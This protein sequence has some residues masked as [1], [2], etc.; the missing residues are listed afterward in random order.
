[1]K[2]ICILLALVLALACV[3]AF[4]AEGDALLGISNENTLNFSYC[5]SQ[6]GTLYLVSYGVLYTYHVG[7]SDLKEYSI[8]RAGGPERRHAAA[9]S[10]PRCP[11]PRT[12]S[13]IPSIWSRNTAR[14]P[15]SRAPL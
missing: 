8:E 10:S 14:T 13:S 6:D 1:M 2:K 3:P 5:F 11:S 9:L 15:S 12:A 4:A 7:D